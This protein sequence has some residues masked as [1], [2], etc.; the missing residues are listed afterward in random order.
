MVAAAVVAALCAVVHAPAV[1]S[2]TQLRIDALA[3]SPDGATLAVGGADGAVRFWDLRTGRPTGPVVGGGG[4]GTGPLAYTRDGS[5]VVGWVGPGIAA[6]SVATGAQVGP[7]LGRGAAALSPDGKTIAVVGR[8]AGEGV[9]LWDVA[10]HRRVSPRFPGSRATIWWAAAFSPDGR[11]LA[12]A[13]DKGVWLWNVRTRRRVG[14]ALDPGTDV[15]SVVFSPDGRLLAFADLDGAQLWNLHARRDAVTRLGLG[16]RRALRDDI[17]E[18]AFS[19]D[20][21]TV[22]TVGV[23]DTSFWNVRT[24]RQILPALGPAADVSAFAFSPDGR[25]FAT[26]DDSGRVQIR[27]TATHAVVAGPFVAYPSPF[28]D[29]AFSRDGA[30]L[31]ASNEGAVDVFD[32]RTRTPLGTIDA[33]TGHTF[34]GFA[35]LGDGSKLATSGDAVRVWSSISGTEVGALSN[36]ALCSPVFGGCYTTADGIAASPDGSMF[37]TFSN[38]VARIW[39]SATLAPLGSRIAIYDGVAVLALAFSPD[40]HTLATGLDQ[41]G[42]TVVLWDTTTQ[43]QIGDPLGKIVDMYSDPATAVAFSPDGVRIAAVT[44]GD[45]IQ[46]WWTATHGRLGMSIPSPSGSDFTSVAFSPDGKLLATGGLDWTIRLWDV[47]TGAEVGPPLR[48]SGPVTSVAFSPDG[49]TLASASYAA[50]RLWDVATRTEL[51]G[52]LAP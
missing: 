23:D 18:L 39:D 12:T 52:P 19:P 3:Y 36:Q 49:R 40:G 13:G 41:Y 10:T 9:T 21:R 34:N 6:W 11:T 15:E 35:F 25:T 7:S 1:G 8:D 43:R 4:G 37:A 38:D 48:D 33:G 2:A 26:G 16:A 44:A 24:G 14:A 51:G 45:T 32:A 29:V 17:F 22:A 50:V 20:G 27:S 46:F 42:E 28:E 47:A 30:M 5:T 31:A